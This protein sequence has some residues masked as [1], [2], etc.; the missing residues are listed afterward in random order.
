L[1]LLYSVA[2]RNLLEDDD[3]PAPLQDQSAEIGNVQN[4]L[5]STNRSLSVAKAEREPVEQTLATQA[6]QLSALQTQLASAKAA[7][8][9]ET[10]L[11]STLKDRMGSQTAEIQKVR[12]ELIR[13]ESDLSAVRVEKAEIEGAFLR[14][15]EDIRELHRKMAET[16][17]EVAGL[18]LEIEKAKK[19]A[20]QQKGLLA[21]ARKQLSTKDAEKTKVQKELEDAK[22]EVEEVSNERESVEMELQKDVPSA[23]QNGHDIRQS[24]FAQSPETDPMIAALAEPLPASLPVSPDPASPSGTS[25]K[26][27]NPFDRL[28]RST[29]SASSPRLQPLSFAD[30]APSATPPPATEDPFGFSRAFPEEPDTPLATK[31]DLDSAATKVGI[32]TPRQEPATLSIPPAP[33]EEQAISPGSEFGS[34]LFSTPPTTADGFSQSPPNRMS[35]V[36]SIDSQFPPLDHVPGSFP[37]PQ[38]RHDGE[39]DLGGPLKE[40]D[41]EES[42]SD[43][44]EEPLSNLKHKLQTSTDNTPSKAAPPNGAST[45]T[46]SFDDAFG[47]ST[48]GTESTDVETPRP[49]STAPTDS[50]ASSF[51]SQVPSIDAFGAPLNKISNPFPAVDTTTPA[52][53]IAGVN[54]F[55][56]AMGKLP[57]NGVASAPDISFDSAFED[58]FDFASAS[59]TAPSFPP[60]PSFGNGNAASSPIFKPTGFQ[61]IYSAQASNGMSSLP[62]VDVPKQLSFEDAFSAAPSAPKPASQSTLPV[63]K[64]SDSP[65]AAISFDDAFGGVDSSQALKLDSTFSSASS[66]V[67]AA[68]S[69]ISQG[70]PAS[71]LKPFPTPQSPPSTSPQGGPSSPRI[72][73]IR[74]STPPPR[75]ASP[76][77]R[78]GSPGPRPSTSSSKE[79][80]EKLKEPAP[81][82]S[83]LSVSCLF[84][85]VFV[86]LFILLYH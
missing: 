76:P 67:S 81:R 34:E 46:T 23:L 75:S 83:R 41:I 1:S 44:D 82:H 47:S 29:S 8:E 66:K 33:V 63:R 59:T 22:S 6:A 27:N 65:S 10:K 5:N 40:L 64:A 38:E 16:G 19:E 79:G 45:L 86:L 85:F 73:S 62:P 35:E 78:L 28:T 18:K 56:E 24:P 72:S 61:A 31:Q 15:K 30:P 3:E 54:A 80:H 48:S 74:S 53:P 84:L 55:D 68:S 2:S 43:S 69:A 17:T 9:T 11:L 71:N 51:T 26:S 20:K 49:S 77:T 13:A 25:V 37:I 39:T 58:N 4:Q 21:I 14:D 12:E 36:P 32:A 7:Y 60:P 70:Q 42:D 52:P 57:G 50:L